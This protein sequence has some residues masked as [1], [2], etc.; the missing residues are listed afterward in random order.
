MIFPGCYEVDA[1]I[2]GRHTGAYFQG[3]G[4]VELLLRSGSPKKIRRY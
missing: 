3:A 1:I 4:A 2:A